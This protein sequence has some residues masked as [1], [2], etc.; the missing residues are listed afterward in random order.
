MSLKLVDNR[1]KSLQAMGISRYIFFSIHNCDRHPEVP[2][3]TIK[4]STEE[5]LQSSGLNFTIFR[6]CGFM[7]VGICHPALALKSAQQEPR[8][9]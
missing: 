5:F 6:L 1:S 4:N 7:Q 9:A 3:M 2:L 8:V